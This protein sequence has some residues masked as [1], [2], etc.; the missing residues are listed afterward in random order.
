MITVIEFDAHSEHLVSGNSINCE[1]YGNLREVSGYRELNDYLPVIAVVD[2]LGESGVKGIL[3]PMEDARKFFILPVH[4]KLY[5]PIIAATSLS[6]SRC[7]RIEAPV[8]IQ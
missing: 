5:E 4:Y 3:P 6:F 2:F 7:K 8:V 1:C